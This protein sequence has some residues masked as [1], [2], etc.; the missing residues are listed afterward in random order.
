VP[1]WPASP[2]PALT[3]TAVVVAQCLGASVRRPH[4]ADL[5][6]PRDA[7]APPGALAYASLRLAAP[8][9]LVGLVLAAAAASG[10][11]WLP[12]LCA[13]PPVLASGLSVA[14]RCAAT[15]PH[16]PLAAGV[17]QRGGL[18]PAGV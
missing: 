16:H 4:R 3:C 11:W 2:R 18:R 7:V 8:T 10:T 13:V 12:L 5:R 9:A 14:G 1:S 17:R 6:S 15:T